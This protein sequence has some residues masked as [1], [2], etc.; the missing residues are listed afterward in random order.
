VETYSTLG[1]QSA[2]ASQLAAAAS[3]QPLC[4]FVFLR[5]LFCLALFL[6]PGLAAR[7]LHFGYGYSH[8]FRRPPFMSLVQ[9]HTGHT[10]D[11]LRRVLD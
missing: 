4:Q 9:T 3:T 1:S 11:A 5:S 10:R 2:I 8:Q 7:C 6:A